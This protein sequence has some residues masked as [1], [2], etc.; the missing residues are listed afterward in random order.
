MGNTS[1]PF[2]HTARRSY[3]WLWLRVKGTFVLEL[4]RTDGAKGKRSR[5]KASVGEP[6]D[7]SLRSVGSSEAMQSDNYD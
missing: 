7:G 5:N 6:A 1:L 4:C 2:V 3:R